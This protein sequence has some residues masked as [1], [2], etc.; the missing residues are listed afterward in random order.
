MTSIKEALATALPILREV[1]LTDDDPRYKAAMQKVA[2]ALA[3]LESGDARERIARII[4]P[5]AFD[6]KLHASEG[7]KSS[8]VITRQSDALAKADAILASGLA[9]NESAI[10]ADER[11]R[12]AKIADE[13]SLS[14]D[15]EWNRNLG[16]ASDLV[17]AC[18]DI[19]AAIRSGG[20]E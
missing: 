20:G 18:E 1:A 17:E 4:D 11:E 9:P 3:S 16:K 19:A 10:R 8:W 13:H 6:Q 12:C 14:Y 15:N 5:K 7:W 2:T